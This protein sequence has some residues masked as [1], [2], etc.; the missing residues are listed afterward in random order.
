MQKKKKTE[1]DLGGKHIEIT[2]NFIFIKVWQPC[3]PV[4]LM[5]G[6]PASGGGLSQE[7]GLGRHPDNDIWWRPLQWS[8]R[9]L[10]ECILVLI[11]VGESSDIIVVNC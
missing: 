6:G 11:S 4:Q 7:E 3:N 9:I 10:L 2:G 1:K 5:A 8:V